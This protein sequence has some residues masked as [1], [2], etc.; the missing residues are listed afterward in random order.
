QPVCSRRPPSHLP[1][2]RLSDRDGISTVLD[3]T[4]AR[5]HPHAWSRGEMPDVN[6]LTNGC[7][8]FNGPCPSAPLD[9]RFPPYASVSTC[10]HRVRHPDWSRPRCGCLTGSRTSGRGCQARFGVVG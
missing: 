9:E 3:R 6:V 5:L 4:S 1:L 8:G 10:A 7:W 2:D